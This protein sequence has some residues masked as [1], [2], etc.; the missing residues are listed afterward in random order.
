MHSVEKMLCI[1]LFQQGHFLTC[2]PF[3]E[4]M[5]RTAVNFPESMTKTAG[6]AETM[7][8]GDFTQGVD[9]A[10]DIVCGVGQTDTQSEL[11][12]AHAHG[13]VEKTGKPADAQ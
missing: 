8:L 5:S 2:I 3:F 6:I 11:S 13:V 12:V 7:A 1:F 10:F 9:P 4:L